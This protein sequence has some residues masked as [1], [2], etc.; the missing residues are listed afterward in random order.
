VIVLGVSYHAR[1]A[2]GAHRWRM[3]HRFTALAWIAGVVHTLGE[4]TDAGQIW[5]LAMLAGPAVHRR[6]GPRVYS[7]AGWRTTKPEN[8]PPPRAQRVPLSAS[9]TVSKRQPATSIHTW[10]ALA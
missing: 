1:H 7:P 10:P 6:A 3:L 4:G 2:I 8:S 5:F 9:A